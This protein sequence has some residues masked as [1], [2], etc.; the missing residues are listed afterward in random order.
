MKQV[1]FRSRITNVFKD[2]TSSEKNAGL[3]L[4]FCAILSVF[5]SNSSIGEHYTHFWHTKIGFD[6]LG[7]DLHYSIEHWINDGIMTVFFLMVGLEIERELYDGELN[8]IKNAIL[9]IVA[10]I[11]GMLVPALLYSS[12]NS[13]LET[14]SGFGIPMGTDI[15]FALGILSLAGNKVPVSI[16]ILLTAIAI[17][18]DLGSILIIALFYG[19]DLNIAYLFASL[20]IFAFLLILNRL[21]VHRMFP[22]LILGVPM[23][24]F[25]MQS[26]IHPTISGVLLAFAFP[27]GKS[28]ENS[29]SIKL[30]H[31]L[32]LPVGFVI[33]PLFTLANTA[34]PIR[35]EFVSSLGDAHAIGIALGLIIGKPLGIL[36]TVFLILK[37]KI[38]K[39]PKS[40]R[41]IDLLA[42]GTL[43]G[44]G[45]TMSIFITQ[46]AFTNE[47][48]V[49]SSKL[50]ILIASS[51]AGFLGLIIF[52][53]KKQSMDSV[54]EL[55]FDEEQDSF[56]ET[57]PK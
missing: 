45:F 29:P 36:S 14:A 50:M 34:I 38:V 54:E 57:K 42:M 24:F 2:F 35:A 52:S 44:I 22:Y 31:M 26:G 33:L 11:G 30:Q 48:H 21:K 27:F 10:A 9:P 49:Q 23:W 6:F 43:A 3:V 53:L 37:L 19:T 7:F 8:P 47:V 4:V 39:L 20:G 55:L 32:H 56:V 18:D 13:G 28:S 41:W 1:I 17:I 5:I 15:A 12:L 25:M 16:K 46:L 51:L 40:V